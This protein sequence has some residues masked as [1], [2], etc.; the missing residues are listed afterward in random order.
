MK[1]NQPKSDLQRHSS[2][3][4]KPAPT[5][6]DFR[7]ASV[8][9][10]LFV[11]F[12]S[13]CASLPQAFRQSLVVIVPHQVDFVELEYYAKR[14]RAAYTSASEIRRQFPQTTRVTTVKSVDVLYFLETDRQ[15]KTQTLTIRGTTNKPNVW[16]DLEIALVKDSR[17]GI[18]LHRGF[19]N[20]AVKIYADVKPYMKRDYSIRVT[21]HS[22]GGAIAA[23]TAGYLFEDDFKVE[24]LVTFGGPKVTDREGKKA[25]QIDIILT[26]V[27][28]DN[29]VVPMIPP[30][31][32]LSGSYQHFGPEV[33]LRDGRKYVYL[34]AHDANRLSV[35]DF[36]RNITDFSTKEHH[37]S[38]YLSNIEEKVQNGTRQVPYFGLATASG[39]GAKASTVSVNSNS[40][41]AAQAP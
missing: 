25:I 5:A 17:L 6:M 14:S 3:Q 24:R 15:Q 26:R 38:A 27:I 12:L 18:N 19:R 28:H 37:M 9:S 22:L 4:F 31:G 10:L 41:Q 40:A 23:I 20:D 2:S 35:G 21:G 8:V 39:S 29:D 30:S 33:I 36:W 16:Q 32:F 13:G 1:R 7:L 11:V 34:P